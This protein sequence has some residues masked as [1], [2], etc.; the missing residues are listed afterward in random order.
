M[1]A[2]D[3]VQQLPDTRTAAPGAHESWI[4]RNRETVDA[5]LFVL[6]FLV[7]YV[8]L[9]IYPVV[10]A[11]LMSVFD[12]DLLDPTLRQF[13]GASNYVE[14]FGGAGLTWDLTHLLVW[15]VIGVVA[16][17]GV[18]VA[19]ARG[20]MNRRTGVVLATVIVLVFVVALGIHPGPDGAWNDALFWG[21]FGNTLL[22]VLL[23]TPTIVGL[24]LL[25]AIVLS[26]SG[27]FVGLLRAAFFA[28]YVL[29]VAVLTLIWGF[30]LNPDLGLIARSLELVGLE[31]I[32]WLTDPS[33]ALPSIVVVT[34]WWT[35]GFNLVLFIAGLQDIEPSLY[36]AASL[37]GA[38][39]W[40]KFRHITLPGLQRT[41]VL[42]T[43]LQ[44]I[45]SFQIFG[46]VFILTRGGPANA[47]RVLI[48]NIYE[49]GF[50]EFRLGYAA[51]QSIFLFV[52]MLGVSAV[53]L[54]LLQGEDET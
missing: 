52:V 34:L 39:A 7:I 38:T 10:Q 47:T 37:D 29:S 53:Q 14:M 45:A 33:L 20:A 46:Q 22:F 4:A 36:E 1:A 48:Q 6:P 43:V 51:A 54:R 42:V 32:S 35:M 5:W 18:G 44:V 8:V 41:L 49:S 25:L 13:V 9:Q 3:Q 2:T 23:S 30:L 15:R 21:S 12:W 19:T 27:R 28:P 16:L 31:P 26:R 17:L 24:A 40:E 50:R 11:M